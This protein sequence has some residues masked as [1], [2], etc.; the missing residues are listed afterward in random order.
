M[1]AAKV[2]RA[3]GWT[4]EARVSEAARASLRETWVSLNHRLGPTR[5][6][7]SW[8]RLHRLRFLPFGPQG[9]TKW[10]V[11]Q[12]LRASGSGQTLAFARYRPGTSFDVERAGLYRV[13]MDLAAS[14]RLLSSL[15]PGQTEHPGHSHFSDGVGR[16]ALSRLSLFAT[17]RL[18]IEEESSER[19]LLEPAP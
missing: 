5:E 1:R 12:S 9:T 15:A 17:S 7:W 11:D 13:A 16:W 18:V 4:D 2:R 6:R 14:D 10:G 3:G 19:L 8:G